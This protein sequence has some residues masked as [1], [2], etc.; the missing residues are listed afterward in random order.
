DVRG[1]IA[2][3]LDGSPEHLASTRMGRLDKLI[4]AKRRGAIALLIAGGDLPAPET[5]SVEVGLLSGAITRDAADAM[6]APAGRTIADATRAL[7][8]ARGPASFAT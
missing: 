3:A 1:K 6:L 4:A 2:L 5:T 7:S 8:A